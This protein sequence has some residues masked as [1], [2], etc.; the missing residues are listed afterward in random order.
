MTHTR[1]LF[2]R[3]IK[4]F[5]IT[6]RQRHATQAA[7]EIH[8]LREAEEILGRL[9]WAESE[10]IEALSVEYW[11]LRKLTLKHDEI[12]QRIESASVDLEESHNQ[13]AELLGMV[14][15][16]TKDLTGERAA[17]TETH[18]RLNSERDII[19][20]DARTVKRLH[21]GIKAKLEVL[22]DEGIQEAPELEASKQE[23]LKLKK[24]FK[25]LRD[26]RDALVVKINSIEKA[27]E[28]IGS[29]I[30][31]RRSQMRDEATDNYQNI[32]KVNR[33]LSDKRAELGS[34]ESDMSALFSK[35]GCYIYSRQHDPSLA[36]LA[37][38]QRG[39]INQMSALSLS[40]D[41]NLRLAGRKYEVPDA[42]TK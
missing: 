42:N 21:D 37:S 2:W 15:D 20:S 29:R 33:D 28:D 17:L 36:K 1:Y 23:L 18:E 35:I 31:T 4:A 34:L 7:S 19:V 9:T 13:R 10:E 3:A 5:G 11:S 14:V 8:L 12:S 40:I 39:L 6:M 26:R 22:A 32:G 16:R 30:E 24:K 27:L 41:F 25:S 38:K